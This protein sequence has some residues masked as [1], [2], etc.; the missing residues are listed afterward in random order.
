MI[1]G[2]QVW[3]VIASTRMVDVFLLRKKSAKEAM[4]TEKY[5][6][7]PT[8]LLD[9]VELTNSEAMEALFRRIR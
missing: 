7:R 4:G 1:D 9:C 3:W 5:L 8:P 2:K 6:N